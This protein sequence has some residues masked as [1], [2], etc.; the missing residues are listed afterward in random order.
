MASGLIPTRTLRSIGLCE[1]SQCNL[2]TPVAD[3]RERPLLGYPTAANNTVA[4]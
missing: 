3:H 4:G 1:D 2:S